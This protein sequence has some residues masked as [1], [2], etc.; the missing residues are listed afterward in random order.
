MLTP[1]DVIYK[2][3]AIIIY[4]GLACY[5]FWFYQWRLNYF[6]YEVINNITI[7]NGIVCAEYIDKI[8]YVM[9]DVGAYLGGLIA[10]GIVSV[11]QACFEIVALVSLNGN[12]Q[13]TSLKFYPAIFMILQ[14]FIVILIELISVMVKGGV[15]YDSEIKY[16]ISGWEEYTE[17]VYLP[18][19]SCS[20]DE[21]KMVYDGNITSSGCTVYGGFDNVVTLCCGKLQ[22]LNHT[23]KTVNRDMINTSGTIVGVVILVYAIEYFIH[24]LLY[25]CNGERRY[26]Q[27]KSPTKSPV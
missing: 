23:I 11:A 12:R 3:F 7:D 24:G 14:L 10:I 8:R 15:Y 17:N 16:D 27:S 22:Y 13:C 2:I 19:L 25:G 5:G 26:Q 1:I 20:S 6:D 21:Y 9:I 4:L 18:L